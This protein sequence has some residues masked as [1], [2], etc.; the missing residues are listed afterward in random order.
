MNILKYRIPS[1]REDYD[2]ELMQ[3]LGITITDS[4][5]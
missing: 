5:I 3:I 2:D 1:N 4:K